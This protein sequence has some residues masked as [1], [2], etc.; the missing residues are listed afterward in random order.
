MVEIP[1][2]YLP[3]NNTRSLGNIAII[4]NSYH[5]KTISSSFFFE[6]LRRDYSLQ[7]FWDTQWNGGK[8][9]SKKEIKPGRFDIIIIWQVFIYYTPKN[10]QEFQCKNIFI[11]PMYDD[12]HAIPDHFF[13]RYSTFSFIAFSSSFQQRF[14][15]LG[16]RSGY[17][18]F[19]PDPAMLPS[20]DET[21]STLHG[22]FW[23]R[24]NDITWDHIRRLI[25]GTDFKSF[26]LHLAIDP[27]WYHEVLPTVEDIEK[28][29]IT[30]SHWFDNKE[31]YLRI[32]Y[33][34]NVFFTPRLYEGIGMPFIEAMTMGKVVVSPDH[35]TMNEYID[36]GINGILY[37]IQAL[38]PLDFSQVKTI[39]NNARQ[40]CAEGYRLWNESK[41]E[42]LSWLNS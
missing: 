31:E 36:N 11:V 37:D 30:I 24:T 32:L 42:L 33:E 26:H 17:F 9:V 34:S 23:Q 2:T 5:F 41:S 22:F 13:M 19:F 7:I 16:I 6:L 27:L 10:L 15:E 29:H 12:A 8:P 25:K 20:R 39:G 28:Y 1:A 40:I 14:I 38:K 18:R 4:D 21:F 35:P 3:C